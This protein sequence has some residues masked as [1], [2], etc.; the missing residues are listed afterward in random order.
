M[1]SF[2]EW[3]LK[4]Q[5]FKREVCFCA[6]CLAKCNYYHKQ[7]GCFKFYN[8]FGLK[9][10]TSHFTYIEDNDGTKHLTRTTWV[11]HQKFDLDEVFQAYL[12]I[13]NIEQENV[14]GVLK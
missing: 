3:L 10:L 12:T 5:G 2:E 14:K 9:A 4:D 7:A 8:P 11:K 1:K 6:T 13:K